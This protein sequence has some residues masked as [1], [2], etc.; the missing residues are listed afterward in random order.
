MSCG[1]PVWAEI[2]LAAI[3]HNM[4]G[5]KKLLK[6][7][8]KFCA[9]IKADGYGH[10]AVAMAVEAVKAGADYLA[11]AILDEARQLRAAAFTEPILIL[12]FTPPAQARQVV[13]GNLTQT[14][15]TLGQ[16]QALSQAASAEG[17]TAKVHIKI[18]SGMG[19]LGVPPAEAAD[20]A[21]AVAGCPGLK[22][23]GVF[24][25]FAMA[26]SRDKSYT[27]KQFT[28]FKAAVDEMK[29]RG[30]Q[31]ELA[32]CAN[33]AA[34]LDLPE[35]HLDMVRAGIVLY[36]LEPS[37]ETGRPFEL[38]PA[39]R[40]MA[41][42]ALIK[43]VPTGTGL[44]YGCT[45]VTEKPSRIGTLPLGYADG[46]TRMLSGKAQVLVGGRRAPVVGRICMD[47]CMVDLTDLPGVTEDDP[48]LLF[49][50]PE[51]PVEEVA[52]KLGTINYEIVC[53]V[54][55]RVPRVYVRR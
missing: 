18:D 37:D 12:G 9:V 26:D 16:A 20:F 15:Y 17:L 48:V 40:L 54:G 50:G 5:V 45:F 14:I 33:S 32:H 6:P 31:I 44:S 53:M 35:M 34:T 11:V 38:K 25:H 41:N 28:A 8:T 24:T 52:A 1:R 4:A 39:M 47:Q 23:E 22:L 43:N 46:W 10:G 55:K 51:L 49:G 3:A 27:H 13:T 42:L 30:L 19:R 21:E 36:G 2:D 7:G 29:R